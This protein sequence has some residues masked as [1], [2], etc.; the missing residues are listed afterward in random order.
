[1]LRGLFKIYTKIYR[2]PC[3]DQLCNLL[4][5]VIVP[6]EIVS[7]ECYTIN[8]SCVRAESNRHSAEIFVGNSVHGMSISNRVH[9][10]KFRNYC[11][12]QTELNPLEFWSLLLENSPSGLW[13]KRR[14]VNVETFMPALRGMSYYVSLKLEQFELSQVFVQC[15]Y[16]CTFH[17]TSFQNAYVNINFFMSL[18]PT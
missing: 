10:R 8:G 15:L 13:D 12:F 18:Y 5:N 2:V 6:K 3:T 4:E 1:M 16:I 7:H 11:N 9:I 17:Y 14:F